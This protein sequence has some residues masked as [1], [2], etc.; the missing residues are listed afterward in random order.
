MIEIRNHATYVLML[1]LASSEHKDATGVVV[2]V[3]LLTVG[4]KA[5]WLVRGYAQHAVYEGT[6]LRSR[7]AT[8][9]LLYATQAEA[10][11][12]ARETYAWLEQFHAELTKSE[13]EG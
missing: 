13:G 1:T 5:A 12:G 8:P 6:E 2:S 10:E 7:T 3:Y 11:L 9:E 4:G